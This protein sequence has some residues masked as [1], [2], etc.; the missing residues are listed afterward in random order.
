MRDLERQRQTVVADVRDLRADVVQD[1][2]DAIEGRALPPTITLSL[3]ASS[4]AT[5]PDT[6]AST[7]SA[8]FARTFSA[9]A[10][11]TAG[12]TV[13]MSTTTLPWPK[14]GQEPVGPSDTASSAFE[15][16]TMTKI[17]SAASATALGESPH[18]IPRSISHCAFERV[19]LYPVTV[20]PLSS[21]R[22]AMRL[23]MAPRPMYPRFAMDRMIPETNGVNAVSVSSRCHARESGVVSPP[24]GSHCHDTANVC[25]RRCSPEAVLSDAVGTGAPRRR[26]AIVV[27]YVSPATGE[28]MRP[29]GDGFIRLI[30]M[31]ISLVIFCTIAAG[32]AGMES[33]RRSVG[34]AARR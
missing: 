23:P 3:P 24:H 7:M 34:S 14:T 19:R 9:T 31:V 1:R 8:P 16:V 29:L 17:T 11:L 26:L 33:I 15:S 21:S 10:R 22:L 13:L 30:T 25:R 27:G 5:L 12:L 28:A 4:V 2:L 20:C 32:I 18:F 6:G